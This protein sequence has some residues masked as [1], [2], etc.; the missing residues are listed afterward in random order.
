MVF[1]ASTSESGVGYALT[2]KEI[3]PL[4]AQAKGRTQRVGTGNCVE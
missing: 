1:A 3:S 4:I 2:S